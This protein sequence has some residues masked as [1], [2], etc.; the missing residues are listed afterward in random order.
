MCNTNCIF[1][2]QLLQ[3]TLCVCAKKNNMLRINGTGSLIE[4]VMKGRRIGH[5]TNF[6]ADKRKVESVQNKQNR[7]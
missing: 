1:V 6:G 7:K 2:L 3:N 4:G 5:C